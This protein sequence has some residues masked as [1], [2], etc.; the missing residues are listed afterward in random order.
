VRYEFVTPDP[1]LL[2]FGIPAGRIVVET[3]DV[4]TT[5]VEAEAIRGEIDDLKVEQHGRDVVIESRSK[6]RLF[7]GNQEFDIRITAP[8]GT[9]A[10][11]NV[12]AADFRATGRLGSLEASTASGDVLVEHV[13]RDAK[14][15]SASGDV[16]LGVVGGRTEVNTAS[17]DIQV[18][19][20]GEGGTMRSA[21]GDVQ[22]REAAK[23]VNLQTASGDMQI[24]SIAEGEVDAKSASGDV[25]VGIRQGSRVHVDARSM[26]GDTTSELQ[27]G[28]VEVASDGP[29]VWVKAATMSGDVRIVRA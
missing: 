29:L 1:P 20:A 9:D 27:L 10:D 6:A 25:R 5:V 17:G 3:G 28:E 4:A 12:S 15:R 19:T 13:E 18:G 14:V 26:S 7:G 11:A 16:Q 22:V 24:E 23:R 8:H 21:S 2:R